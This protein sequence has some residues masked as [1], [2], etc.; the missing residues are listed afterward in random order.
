MEQDTYFRILPRELI[1]ELHKYF[2]KYFKVRELIWLNTYMTTQNQADNPDQYL[3]SYT[4][5]IVISD[6]FELPF[7]TQLPTLKLFLETAVLEQSFIFIDSKRLKIEEFVPD[8]NVK[9]DDIYAS[10]VAQLNSNLKDFKIS[11]IHEEEQFCHFWYWHSE[12]YP[13][14]IYRC[15][16]L[17]TE[18]LIY[19]LVQFYNDIILKKIRTFY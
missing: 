16:L 9:D 6:K 11:I 1:T 3:N 13:T 17:E 15:D 10:Q 7:A 14:H 2:E 8:I 19:K 4:F 18:V 12:G 5:A